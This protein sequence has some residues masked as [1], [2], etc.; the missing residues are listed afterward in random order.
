VI[1]ILASRLDTE[2]RALAA[3]W[4]GAD[5][6]VLSA[7][8]LGSPGWQFDPADAEAGV[9]V[10]DGNRVKTAD[11]QA[12]LTRRPSVLAEEL[13][14]IDPADRAYVAAE[15]NAFLVAWLSALSCPVVNRP[16][17]TSLCGPAWGTWHWQAAAARSGIRWAD[18][19]DDSETHDAVVCGSAC[20][21]AQ[22]PIETR[23]AK[24]LAGAAGVELLAVRFRA[25]GVCGA[26]VAPELTDPEL[27]AGLLGHLTRKP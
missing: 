22:T 27:R 24:A 23:A 17:T 12:V 13:Q 26:S 25:S 19:G 9:A 8:D 7:E 4:S 3:A 10:I 20:F 5:A 16:T 14:R 1:A 6:A 15:T 2:A 18:T 21:A 11:L